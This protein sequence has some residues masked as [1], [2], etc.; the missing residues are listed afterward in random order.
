MK[1][2]V[3]IAFACAL[4]ATPSFAQDKQTVGGYLAQGFD[5]IHTEMGSP[6]IQF[7]L[8]KDAQLVSCSVDLRSGDTSSCRTIK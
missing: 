6:F 8:K 1:L 4:F 2:P 3:T 5:V 7:I